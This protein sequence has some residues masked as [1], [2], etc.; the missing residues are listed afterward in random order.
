M[1]SSSI[2]RC[3]ILGCSFP[4]LGHRLPSAGFRA[5]A[6]E[7]SV[8]PGWVSARLSDINF[9]VARI[10]RDQQVWQC[11]VSGASRR[12]SIIGP[13]K[14]NTLFR[15]PEP[16]AVIFVLAISHLPMATLT[17]QVSMLRSGAWAIWAGNIVHQVV[18]R[19]SPRRNL[20]TN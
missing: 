16:T 3:P 1:R 15:K 8:S 5:R 2:P 14:E 11:R 6:S 12:I 19:D 7:R 18:F 10:L 17:K 4:G 20:S 9:K 13:A